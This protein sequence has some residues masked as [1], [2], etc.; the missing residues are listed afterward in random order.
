MLRNNIYELGEISDFNIFLKFF[1]D[2]K[3]GLEELGD[4]SDHE[5]YIDNNTFYDNYL[6]NIF[7]SKSNIDS[8]LVKQYF[9]NTRL[10]E[11]INRSI[12]N[13]IIGKKYW[14]NE[15]IFENLELA[16]DS[17]FYFYETLGN[18]D[19]FDNF[20]QNYKIKNNAIYVNNFFSIENDIRS[21]DDL[22]NGLLE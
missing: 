8:P 3:I 4:V 16:V 5:I 10:E 11:R 6:K 1:R 17:E 20:Y 14:I 12:D 7:S 21:F 15:K 18:V 19:G 13:K 9:N 22:V 2:I